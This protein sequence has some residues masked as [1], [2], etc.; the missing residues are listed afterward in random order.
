MTTKRKILILIIAFPLFF[1]LALP[2]FALE[3]NY[4]PVPGAE[5]PQ[6]FMQRVEDGSLDPSNALPLYIK[7]FYHLI[8]SLS[9]L[10]CFFSIVTGAFFFLLPGD[11]A[12]RA[13]EGRERINLGFVGL[14]LMLSS[15]LFLNVLN[16]DLLSFTR[17]QLT[18]G[19]RVPITPFA[20]MSETIPSYVEV[21]LGGLIQIVE[22]RSSVTDQMSAMVEAISLTVTNAA[23]CLDALTAACQC[24]PNVPTE[25]CDENA[26][27]GC[28]T[29]ECLLDPCNIPIPPTTIATCQSYGQPVSG[30][31]RAAITN[32]ISSLQLITA[33][34]GYQRQNLIIVTNQLNIA[35]NNLRAAEALMRDARPLSFFDRNAW[36][37]IQKKET[38]RIWPFDN[39]LLPS[40]ATGGGAGSTEAS[41]IRPGASCQ[42]HSPQEDMPRCLLCYGDELVCI[43]NN[44]RCCATSGFVSNMCSGNDSCTNPPRHADQ[45]GCNLTT[46]AGCQS[47]RTCRDGWY[48][49]ED[50][51]NGIGGDTLQY[52]GISYAIP[53]GGAYFVGSTVMMACSNYR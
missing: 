17:I 22:R 40:T 20:E 1:S 9:G 23:R 42:G 47:P 6:D 48:S 53:A 41:S 12:T 27:G 3:V 35:N 45:P 52:N 50:L 21:P 18:P 14:L 34:L 25:N 2:V 8:L 28:T 43:G 11:S 15:Y 29:G 51:S 4:P 26:T 49:A 32:Q 31:L 44:Y 38:R 36:A 19:E 24:N 46:F 7:Y 37:S 5:A 13:K 33:S 10:A 30:N 16:P 39:I